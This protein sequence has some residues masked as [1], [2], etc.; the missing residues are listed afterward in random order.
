MT[1]KNNVTIPELSF[2][3]LDL[4]SKGKNC[5]QLNFRFVSKQMLAF[6]S[7]LFVY[8]LGTISEPYQFDWAVLRV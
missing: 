2:P 1:S 4:V 3:S 5:A 8:G 7:L 6:V